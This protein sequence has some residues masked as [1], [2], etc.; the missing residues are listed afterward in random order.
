[1]EVKL[2]PFIGKAD[3]VGR[4]HF[5]EGMP[6]DEWMRPHA[7]AVRR[8]NGQAG[9]TWRSQQ[10]KVEKPRRFYLL[11]RTHHHA[12]IN[13]IGGTNFVIWTPRTERHFFLFHG[14]NTNAE[15]RQDEI[16]F[17]ISRRIREEVF[18]FAVAL[19]AVPLARMKRKGLIA[20]LIAHSKRNCDRDTHVC[21]TPSAKKKE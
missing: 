7:K 19:R 16:L 1:M 9:R 20:T 21:S 14:G 11:K 4:A 10:R 2:S 15:L 8:L 12:R 5:G 3:A 18:A 13:Q 17:Q 6:A